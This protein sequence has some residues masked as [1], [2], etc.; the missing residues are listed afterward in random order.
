MHIIKMNNLNQR[1]LSH[2][3]Q[4]FVRDEFY[5]NLWLETM[6]GHTLYVFIY[7]LYFQN[8]LIYKMWL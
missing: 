2:I 7:L 4:R 5:R 1:S 8:D 3:N 6:I